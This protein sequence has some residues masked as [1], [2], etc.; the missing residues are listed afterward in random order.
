[1]SFSPINF[2]PSN[3]DRSVP[4]PWRTARGQVGAWD[5]AQDLFWSPAEEKAYTDF[6]RQ[7]ATE[8]RSR[9]M[10]AVG[11]LQQEL[12]EKGVQLRIEADQLAGEIAEI[13]S[14]VR[15]RTMTSA[16]AAR[17]LGT[18]RTQGKN[19]VERLQTYRKTQAENA[20]IAADP[21]AYEDE[22]KRA[23]PTLEPTY[24]PW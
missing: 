9:V 21:W 4:R 15:D 19:L 6:Y 8:V 7:R 16:E 24:W 18:L 14:Q 23:F 17:K 2:S 11:S 20:Q 12:V 22:I 1:M 5:A 10:A 13:K 3:P